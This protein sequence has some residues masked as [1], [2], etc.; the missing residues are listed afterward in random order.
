MGSSGVS[1]VLMTHE[2]AFRQQQ[3]QR[4]HAERDD[5]GRANRRSRRS[6]RPG[7]FSST[8]AFGRRRRLGAR[9]ERRGRGSGSATRTKDRFLPSS[10]AKRRQPRPVRASSGRSKAKIGCTMKLPWSSATWRTGLMRFGC[11]P[12][13][14][15]TVWKRRERPRAI[16]GSRTRSGQAPRR[17]GIYGTRFL[18]AMAHKVYTAESPYQKSEPFMMH[19]P[20]GAR[21]DAASRSAG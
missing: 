20:R 17:C 21:R 16:A 12:G 7:C 2:S 5:T 19:S 1:E 15:V 3:G 11:W 13:T 6:C 9:R 8:S 4:R 14:A 10:A 18:E